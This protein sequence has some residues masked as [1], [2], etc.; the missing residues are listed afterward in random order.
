MDVTFS[1][2]RDLAYAVLSAGKLACPGSFPSELSPQ[3]VETWAY[4]IHEC[5]V[6]E[7]DQVWEEAVR[8]LGVRK[9]LDRQA[10]LAD[11]IE[12]VF[13]VK[14]RWRANPRRRA[15]LEELTEI[16]KEKKYERLGFEYQR[17]QIP[18]QHP[19]SLDEINS[20]RV[21]VGAAP[22]RPQIASQ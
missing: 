3:V 19:L 14:A 9:Q 21:S 12:M 15:I 4:S 8:L 13:E 6:K 20:V 16:R 18:P 2:P 5:G 11:V 1:N 10:V 17:P 22:L 7:P